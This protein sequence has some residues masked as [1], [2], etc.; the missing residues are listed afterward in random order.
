MCDDAALHRQENRSQREERDRDRERKMREQDGE[1][2]VLG[3]QGRDRRV[4]GKAFVERS[5]GFIQRDFMKQ[6]T[7][8]KNHANGERSHHH[9]LMFACL[10][11]L[12]L[13]KPDAQQHDCDGV[14]R[15]GH[16]RQVIRQKLPT[17]DFESNS[18]RMSA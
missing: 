4:A 9:R 18:L 11:V 8:K 17:Q 13:I 10:P 3:T 14:Q 15:C 5:G 12:D 2:S 6:V 7:G 16:M 1:V